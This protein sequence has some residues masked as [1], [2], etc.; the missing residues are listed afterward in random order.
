MLRAKLLHF[1]SKPGQRQ[2]HLLQ[3]QK[4]SPSPI[5]AATKPQLNL[6]SAGNRNLRQVAVTEGAVV[7]LARRLLLPNWHWIQMDSCLR[8]L[9]VSGLLAV[10]AGSESW[11]QLRQLNRFTGAQ[12]ATIAKQDWLSYL[13]MGLPCLLVLLCWFNLSAF[14]SSVPNGHLIQNYKL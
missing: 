5:P 3:N 6:G 4:D 8:R 14:A 1:N 7:G 9:P 13:R 11:S 10:T 12:I 2:E